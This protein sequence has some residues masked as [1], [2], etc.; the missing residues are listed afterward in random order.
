MERQRE[1]TTF[2]NIQNV[3]IEAIQPK[4]IRSPF[5]YIYMIYE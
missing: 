3:T 5:Y 1:P 2:K 4:Q